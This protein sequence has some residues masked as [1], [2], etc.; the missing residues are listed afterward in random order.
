MKVDEIRKLKQRVMAGRVSNTVAIDLIE[1]LEDRIRELEAV[2]S[3][4]KD[5]SDEL[6]GGYAWSDTTME[7]RLFSLSE[8]CLQA[9]AHHSEE[10][11]K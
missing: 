10:G 9:L 3:I 7:Q 5:I 11:T 6:Y 4:A 1:A 2:V 8:H